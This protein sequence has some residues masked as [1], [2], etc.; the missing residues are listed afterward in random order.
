MSTFVAVRDH[1]DHRRVNAG[2]RLAQA[3]SLALRCAQAG[4]L[5][6]LRRRA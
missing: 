6:L 2:K 5:S 4:S 1:S 3:G